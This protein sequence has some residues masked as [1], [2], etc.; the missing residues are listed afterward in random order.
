MPMNLIPGLKSLARL[1]L[2]VSLLAGGRLFAAD[3]GTKAAP[4]A[5][6]DAGGKTGPSYSMTPDTAPPTPELLAW[7]EAF[8]ATHD[9]RMQW[10]RRAR[11]GMFVHWGV[12]SVPAGVWNGTNV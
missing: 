12:Y 11:F 8:G 9:E 6:D 10:W 2:T 1:T 4:G 7:Q 5:V 3:A